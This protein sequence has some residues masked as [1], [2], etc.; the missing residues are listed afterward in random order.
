MK[1]I[2]QTYQESLLIALNEEFKFKIPCR[3]EIK[4]EKIIYKNSKYLELIESKIKLGSNN[5]TLYSRIKRQSFSQVILINELEQF[6]FQLRYRIGCKD[7]ILEFPGGAVD[8]NETPKK[9][10]EREMKEELGINNINLIELG[11]CYIDPMRSE[12]KGYYFKSNWFNSL[13][14]FTAFVEGELEESYFFW[15][16]KEQIKKYFS[17]LASS[18]IIGLYLI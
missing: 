16:G 7:Y 11:S 9:A 12:F 14:P 1:E 4:E 5:H 13:K 17:L 2:G 10:A 8:E 6:L 18:A 15:M 3:T